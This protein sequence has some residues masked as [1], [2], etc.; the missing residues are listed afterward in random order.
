MMKTNV[1]VHTQ[2][3]V[4]HAT[5]ICWNA[6]TIS[7]L[8]RPLQ[9]AVSPVAVGVLNGAKPFTQVVLNPIIGLIVDK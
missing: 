8:V 6:R 3:S 2:P 1:L 5:L 4:F 9:D 7:L